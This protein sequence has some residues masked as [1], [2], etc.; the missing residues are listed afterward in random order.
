M[1][2]ATTPVIQINEGNV[3]IGTTTPLAKLDIQGT[4]GQLFSVT[5]NL[6]GSIFAVA[7]ISG[8]PIF[9]V[10]SSGV[11]YFDSKVYINATASIPNRTEEFQVTGTQIITNTG[12]NS[13][14]LYLGYNSS[15]S[16]SVQLGRGRTADGSSYIDLNGEVMAAG[17]YGFRIRRRAGV[18]AITDLIQVGTGS[19]TINALNGADTVFTN[20]NVGIGVTSSATKL[21]ISV[22]P[23]APWMKLINANETAFNLTTYN[24][25]TNNG[26]SV[27]AFKH[28]LYY[29][30]TENAAVT[31]Y[32]GGSSVGGFLTFTT[33]NG[34][35]RMRIDS[36][37][38]VGIGVTT[39]SYKLEVDG[40]SKISGNVI[41]G[42]DPNTY[43]NL[44]LK[45]ATTTGSSSKSL[46]IISQNS[47]RSFLS[48][49]TAGT[50]EAQIGF[51]T[52]Q[53][54]SQ[55]TAG[56][57]QY[58]TA[59][60]KF[61][62]KTNYTLALTIAN[63]QAATFTSTV[64]ATNFI[65]S[66]DKTLKNNIKEI[67]TN[68]IDVNWKNFELKSEPGVK[69]AGVI[70]QELEEKHPEFVRTDG[71]GIKSVAYIDLLITKIAELEAR[72]E[73]AGI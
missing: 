4:Q 13:P 5:D 2:N 24:N 9:D 53:Y 47:G 62:F 48:L 20:T 29:G 26:S 34:A 1:A 38:N 30:S 50:G 15:G 11:S 67:D 40:L 65:L 12:T 61:T 22:T 3:G 25:G 17:D 33:N 23:S 69:R 73:K 18:N 10:N 72:L 46:H 35:E 37:G 68:H 60:N 7:D 42:T 8:V 55:N 43:A 66:S 58:T 51:G 19:L 45:D 16:N 44:T 54:A 36:S 49:V 59:T 21:D 70:A 64:T 56:S 31:F 14:A 6:S 52:S 71:E 63:N 32:R 28:G 27:Y 39:T 41:I 57:I